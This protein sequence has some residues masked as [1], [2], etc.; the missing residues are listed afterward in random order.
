MKN[1]KAQD[2]LNDAWD[3]IHHLEA[4]SPGWKSH[5]QA[6]VSRLRTV[7]DVLKNEDMEKL[8]DPAKNVLR[9]RFK[10]HWQPEGDDETWFTAFI[11]PTRDDIQHRYSRTPTH[12]VKV[13]NDGECVVVSMT[14]EWEED[15]EEF[16]DDAIYLLKE[17][18]SWVQSELDAIIEEIEEKEDEED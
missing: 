17:A 13:Y 16:Q 4:A 3:A 9:K 6:A 5:W 14:L 2:V 7:C 12:E 15:G 10:S 8:S 11:K 18:A 1:L